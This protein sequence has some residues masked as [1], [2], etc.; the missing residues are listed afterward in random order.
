MART[1][2]VVARP[3]DGLAAAQEAGHAREVP[4]Q[5]RGR[6]R[7]DAPHPERRVLRQHAAVHEH[8]AADLQHDR[9]RRQEAPRDRACAA[10]AWQ[11]TISAS[12][13]TN[14][15]PGTT[16]NCWSCSSPLVRTHPAAWRADQHVP[17]WP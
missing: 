17:M 11:V 6:V 7:V 16:Y 5:P 14:G 12:A 10:H 4:Q 2:G 1:G 8:R 15:M 9:V 3:H 13:L